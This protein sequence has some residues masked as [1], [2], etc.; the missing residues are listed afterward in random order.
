[1]AIRDHILLSQQPGWRAAL[2]DNVAASA[3]GGHLELMPAPDSPKTLTGGSGSMGGLALPVSVALD[4]CDRVYVV[5]SATQTIRRFDGCDGVFETLDCIGGRGAAPRQLDDARGI[6]ISWFNDFFIADS[7]NRRVQVFSLG[8]LA[9]RAIWGPL[10]AVRNGEEITVK[11]ADPKGVVGQCGLTREFPRETWTP[12]DVA[13]ACTGEVY[14]ADYTNGLI[15]AFDAHGCWRAAFT[16]DPHAP[17]GK[18][19]R[20]V[21]DLAG[22][23]YVIDEGKPEVT[24]MDRDGKPI[25]RIT[26]TGQVGKMQPVAIAL[27]PDGHLHISYALTRRITVVCRDE[28]GAYVSQRYYEADAADLVFDL[29]G[30]AIVAAADG[31]ISVVPLKA[32][33]QTTGRYFSEG[34]D[35]RIYQ[36][37]WHRIRMYATIPAGTIVRV[38][39]LTAEAD[40]T[41]AEVLTLPEDRWSRGQIDSDTDSCEWDC[42]V[43]SPPGRFLFLRL[44]LESDGQASPSI[45]EI[46]T[47]YPR[48]SSIQYLPAVFRE[49]P[50]GGLFLDRYLSIV[51]HFREQIADCLDD[52]ACLFDP[53]STPA[54]Q[55]AGLGDPDFLAW[56]ASW[57][58]LTLDRHWSVPKRRL[59]LKNAYKLYALRGT[60]AGLR[61]HIK[62]YTGTEPGILEHYRMRQ[63]ITMDRS[64]LN[65]NTSLWGEELSKRFE[66]DGGLP[67]GQFQLDDTQDPLRDA[68]HNVAHRFSVFVP[69]PGGGDETS[70]QTIERIVEMAKPAHTEARIYV[71]RPKFRI[72]Y[73][74][75][76]G[77]DTMVGRYP[78]NV[79]SGAARLGCD[80]VLGKT[81]C[82]PRF[83]IGPR[84]RIGSTTRLN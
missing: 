50:E 78:E 81:N 80:S 12:V 53:M 22:N 72:G 75:F 48:N 9:L 18:P 24:V 77:I 32:L 35:S 49:D 36:C 82:P 61:L 40:K 60:P 57:L 26:Q 43:A 69:V 63:W 70:R 11:P 38:D 56:L 2:L 67:L 6:A 25:A 65:A 45:E 16:G 46:R 44:T 83:E 17:L 7:G 41:I 42:L 79:T 27:D 66:L 59:L 15:H 8:G 34:L 58:D 76:L 31:S 3:C 74:S 13:V 14:V 55:N 62:L 5:D 23:I 52:I 29:A 4:R 84:S 39:T 64:R 21:V 73:Q 1:M 71:I 30:N 54:R 47:Y 51:D 33:Y 68:F 20:V 19:V 28:G 37:V 10:Q